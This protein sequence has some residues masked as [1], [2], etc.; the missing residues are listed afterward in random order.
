MV[1]RVPQPLDEPRRRRGGCVGLGVRV[2]AGEDLERRC[3]RCGAG[4]GAERLDQGRLV[5]EAHAES[6]LLVRDG[7]AV[8]RDGRAVG[9]AG[10]GGGRRVARAEDRL[11]VRQVGAT[12][13]RLEEAVRRRVAGDED[14]G[15]V[16]RAAVEGVREA[17]GALR[18]RDGGGR[19][20]V[21]RGGR[22]QVR[23]GR[24]ERRPSRERRTARERV[25]GGGRPPGL[26]RAPGLVPL[27]VDRPPRLVL[28]SLPREA[29]ISPAC[30]VADVAADLEARAVPPAA[31]AVALRRRADRDARAVGRAR[32]RAPPPAQRER[33][34]RMRRL[35]LAALGR[36]RLALASTAAAAAAVRRCE[37][38]AR[39]LRSVEAGPDEDAAQS[40]QAG[41]LG[42]ELGQAVVLGLDGVVGLLVQ[43][44]V[45]ALVIDE[46]NGR[47]RGGPG[48]L[49][50]GGA[51]CPG[52]RGRGAGRGRAVHRALERR[53]EAVEVGLDD[54][55]GERRARWAEGAVRWSPGE[56]V[57]SC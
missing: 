4:P 25:R 53:A 13:W 21:G 36:A 56:A 6:R 12:L 30:G 16:D 5:G 8:D 38:P 32:A 48:A 50:E 18:R 28:V 39:A 46:G 44:A 20:V 2:G 55:E 45:L 47:G 3:G 34:A 11:E 40:R 49:F 57:T 9:E 52:E 29:R 10:A 17:R 14:V 35:S 37:G 54:E 27:A 42:L 41:V 23:A 33:H 1:Q 22:R 15:Q 26:E 24:D 51:W 43:R 7:V 19:G 31:R